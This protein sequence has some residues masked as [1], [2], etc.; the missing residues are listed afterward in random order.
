MLGKLVRKVTTGE[1]N[2]TTKRCANADKTLS[3]RDTYVA[4]GNLA[5]LGRLRPWAFTL[6]INYVNPYSKSVHFRVTTLERGLC[7]AVMKEQTRTHNPF[8]SI[9]AGALFT[10][11]ETVSAMA[12]FSRLGTKSRAIP[13]GANIEYFKK[14]RGLITA[15]AEFSPGE[16]AGRQEKTSELTIVDSYLD[17]VAKMSIQ[18]VIDTK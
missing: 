3:I 6:L 17:T 5:R 8:N 15:T 18:W 14:A 7:T 11:G 12:V 13:T 10:F 4:W 9:H 1:S 2:Y 16:L